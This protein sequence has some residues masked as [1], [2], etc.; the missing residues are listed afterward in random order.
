VTQFILLANPKI[1]EIPDW[2][3]LDDVSKDDFYSMISKE[4]FQDLKNPTIFTAATNK[5]N[6]DEIFVSSQRDLIS[7]KKFSD[8]LAFK[9]ITGI[10]DHIEG[11]ALWYGNDYK[12]LENCP[13]THQLLRK[14]E[15][16]LQEPTVEAYTLYMNK[17]IQPKKQ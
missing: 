3:K 2:I 6:F 16:G 9:L 13:N 11:M 5:E 14:I 12:N 15:K 10:T 1:L 17:L 7:G 4:V 8:T